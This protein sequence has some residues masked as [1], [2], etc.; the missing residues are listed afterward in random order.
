[1]IPMLT[2][3]FLAAY[4]AELSLH[5]TGVLS[6]KY[7]RILEKSECDVRS[8]KVGASVNV[9]IYMDLW[10]EKYGHKTCFIFVWARDSGAEVSSKNRQDRAGVMAVIQKKKLSSYYNGYCTPG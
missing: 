2:F 10:V 7:G 4:I 6:V 3:N 5:Q 9:W 1:M 8:S